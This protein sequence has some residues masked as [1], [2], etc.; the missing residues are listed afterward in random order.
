MA[1]GNTHVIKVRMSNQTLFHGRI[2]DVDFG[3]QARRHCQQRFLTHQTVFVCLVDRHEL[4]QAWS[5]FLFTT[6]A[7]Y[8]CPQ[9]ECE[10]S[11]TTHNTIA[12]TGY[13]CHSKQAACQQGQDTRTKH[14]SCAFRQASQRRGDAKD[15]FAPLASAAF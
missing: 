15:R 7:K 1:T 14:I 5:P 8:F 13:C 2:A 10:L 3:C 12:P 6:H 11:D 4:M 9:A